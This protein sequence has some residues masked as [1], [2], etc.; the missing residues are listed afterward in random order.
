MTA[1][2]TN[3]DTNTNKRPLVERPYSKPRPP[4]VP[5][6]V[7]LREL[8]MPDG[9]RLLVDRRAI[10][11]LAEGKPDEFGTNPCASSASGRRRKPSP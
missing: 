8:S 3:T 1:T 11:F 2:D 9:R 7:H 4:T 6:T 10:A 5:H